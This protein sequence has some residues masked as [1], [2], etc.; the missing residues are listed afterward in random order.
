M[1]KI[2]SERIPIYVWGESVDDAT[3]AQA[4][5]L[6]NLPFAADHIALMPDAHV[7]FGMPIGGVL[8]TKGQVIPHAVGLD[9]GCGVRAWK[10]NVP[11]ADMLPWRDRILNDVQR[12]I[13]QG[14]EWHRGSQAHRT[15]LFDRVPGVAVLRALRRVARGLIAGSTPG[16]L[17]RHRNARSRTASGIK[18]PSPYRF[19]PTAAWGV[20]DTRFA[21]CY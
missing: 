4:R 9:I 2:D 21:D 16:S 8:A 17:E 11:L 15:D 5:N 13:P 6:A 19:V 12:T 14:F 1:R 20:I 18:P 3:L 10:T 7:G